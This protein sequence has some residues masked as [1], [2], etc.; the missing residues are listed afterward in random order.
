MTSFFFFH[1]YVSFP[2][3]AYPNVEIFEATHSIRAGHHWK[4][5]GDRACNG[6]WSL[7]IWTEARNPMTVGITGLVEASMYR[8]L[9]FVPSNICGSCQVSLRLVLRYLR[10]IQPCISLGN[11]TLTHCYGLTSHRLT[12]IHWACSG[13]SYSVNSRCA[14]CGS[15]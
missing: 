12:F 3:H 8:K 11:Q 10:C 15:K 6:S 9:C 13:S 4:P 14:V 5:N 1:E 7:R 2:Q